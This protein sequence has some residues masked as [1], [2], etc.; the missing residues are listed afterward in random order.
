MERNE[1]NHCS[2]EY[3]CNGNV[4]ADGVPAKS[5]AKAA[6]SEQQQSETITRCTEKCD[7]DASVTA[8][9]NTRAAKLRDSKEFLAKI[10]KPE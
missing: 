5:M 3:K 7:K 8:L 4:T 6:T 1:P 9:S 10:H 2:K